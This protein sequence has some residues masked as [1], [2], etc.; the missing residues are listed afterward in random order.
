MCLKIHIVNDNIGI[1]EPDII[2]LP[3]HVQLWSE[4]CSMFQKCHLAKFDIF[5]K[6]QALHQ[7]CI[8]CCSASD[9]ASV[10]NLKLQTYDRVKSS[11]INNYKQNKLQLC[12]SCHTSML[13]F[14]PVLWLLC[15]WLCLFEL[16]SCSVEMSVTSFNSN[17]R[18][19]TVTIKFPSL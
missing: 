19:N 5:N 9:T 7:T 6:L 3:I 17:Q 10:N 1:N 11:F 8:T 2:V 14:K 15:S 12:R 16:L 4:N 13:N 18:I